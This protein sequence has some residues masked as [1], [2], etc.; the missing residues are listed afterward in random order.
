MKRLKRK[1]QNRIKRKNQRLRKGYT[2][3]VKTLSHLELQMHD[4]IKREVSPV[5]RLP[6]QL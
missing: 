1:A 6:N 4:K 2:K 5:R 3:Q